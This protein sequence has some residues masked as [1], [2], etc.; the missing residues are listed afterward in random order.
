[1]TSRLFE[2]EIK[3]WKNDTLKIVCIGT[4]IYIYIYAMRNKGVPKCF[5]T[6]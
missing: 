2:T 3:L 1:M 6:Y 4:H 5:P